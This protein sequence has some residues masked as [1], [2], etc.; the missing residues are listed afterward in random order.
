MIPVLRRLAPAGAVQASN[1]RRRLL[2]SRSRRRQFRTGFFCI[3]TRLFLPGIDSAVGANCVRPQ[4]SS[5]SVRCSVTTVGAVINRP[6]VKC[7]DSTSVFGEFVISY[8][9]ADDIRPYGV[10]S[11]EP[12][13]LEFCGRT[14]F[15][16]T[17][18]S[19]PGKKNRVTIQE[20][21]VRNW[22]SALRIDT[23]LGQD[24]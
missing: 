6:A 10:L 21:P 11:K 8:C 17:A 16:P 2:A 1:R 15:A 4:N 9:R 13:K 24:A 18:E 12:D 19:I 7:C 5:L 3:V 14:Q 23:G 22:L 20:N